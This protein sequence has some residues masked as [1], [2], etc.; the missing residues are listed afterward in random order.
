MTITLIYRQSL[1]TILLALKITYEANFFVEK[2][3]QYIID[4]KCHEAILNC[5]KHW[6][7]IPFIPPI[8]LCEEYFSIQCMTELVVSK[9]CIDEPGYD[10]FLE[11]IAAIIEDCA[12]SG[13]RW[14]SIALKQLIKRA[15]EHILCYKTQ[16]QCYNI[17]TWN[18]QEGICDINFPACIMRTYAEKYCRE[19]GNDLELSYY[20]CL[21][22][23]T[24]CGNKREMINKCE[25]E[26]LV[27]IKR[28]IG[29]IDQKRHLAAHKREIKKPIDV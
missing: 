4:E 14:T 17:T 27:E 15:M 10:D 29:E 6:N 5:T 21:S 16:K 2:I 7:T 1:F 22:D 19:F 25:K 18:P 28:I 13:M 3:D 24:K 20:V 8:G 23:A 26:Y 9:N 12:K 11:Q